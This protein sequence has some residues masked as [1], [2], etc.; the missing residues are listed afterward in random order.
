MISNSIPEA[1][2]IYQRKKTSGKKKDQIINEGAQII[3]NFVKK[4]DILNSFL[5]S[6]FNKKNEY[7]NEGNQLLT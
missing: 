1:L 5:K 7:G 4:A 2:Q 3:N 6:P